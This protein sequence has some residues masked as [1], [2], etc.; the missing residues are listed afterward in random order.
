M[1][2]EQDAR[3]D[4]RPGD[5]ID[6]PRDSYTVKKRTGRGDVVYINDAGIERVVSLR[7]WKKWLVT[8]PGARVLHVAQEG[9]EG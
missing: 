2:T 4:P 7:T 1:R 9:G 3:R 8:G 6:H 5:V